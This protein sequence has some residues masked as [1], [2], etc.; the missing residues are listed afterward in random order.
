VREP[1]IRG[2]GHLNTVRFADL[3]A[4]RADVELCS[5]EAREDGVPYLPDEEGRYEAERRVLV[6]TW[7][8]HVARLVKR[9]HGRLPLVYYQQSMDWGFDLP[10]DVPVVSMSRYMMA[11]AQREWPASPQLYIPQAL[12]DGCRLQGLERDVDVLVVPRKQPSYVL[13]RL[14]SALD[15]RCRLTV[16][17]RFLPR[18]EL[19]ELFNRTKVY[20]YAFA[21]QRSEH[22]PG[23]WRWMEGVATQT[24]EATLCGCTVASDLRGGHADFLE[25]ERWGPRLMSHSLDWD[26]EQILRAMAEHPL[27]GQ[28]DRAVA[29]RR[30]YDEAAALERIDVFLAFLDR[31][32]PFTATHP[33]RPPD[34]ALPEPTPLW[35]RRIDRG[36]RGLRRRLRTFRRRS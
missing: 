21:P 15:G 31:Y 20:V 32:L 29:L 27:P 12:P 35:R 1:R 10:A 30:D 8:P 6:V 11:W 5:Y 24:L 23:G 34:F 14:A 4:R 28:L 16:L 22:G 2:G 33:P 7:G 13:D 3:L 19:Y 18:D 9:F 26:V 17:D 25:P 36:L